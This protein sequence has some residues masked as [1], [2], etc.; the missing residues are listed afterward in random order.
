MLQPYPFTL[1]TVN[2]KFEIIN[3]NILQLNIDTIEEM[4]DMP[5]M[6]E[7]VTNNSEAP[8]QGFIPSKMDDMNT[9]KAQGRKRTLWC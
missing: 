1:M 3:E 8:T 5:V 2:S 4:L 6:G 7:V 9:D